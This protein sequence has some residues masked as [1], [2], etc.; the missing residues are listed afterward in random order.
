MIG[1]RHFDTAELPGH[2]CDTLVVGRNNYFAQRSRLMALL[3]HMLDER[4]A[5]N[6]MQRL[7]RKT[8]GGVAGRNDADNVHC[9]STLKI[10]STAAGKSVAFRKPTPITFAP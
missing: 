4:L 2:G 6:R 1:P 10:Q 9:F 7:A 8:C 3:N 5:S